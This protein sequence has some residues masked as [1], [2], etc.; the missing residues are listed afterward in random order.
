MK[1]MLRKLKAR[2]VDEMQKAMKIAL[3]CFTKS[4]IE[5]LVRTLRI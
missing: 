4:D 3:D 1:F 2:T 5:N